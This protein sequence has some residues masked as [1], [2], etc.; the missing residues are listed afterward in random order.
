MGIIWSYL[1]KSCSSFLPQE[2]LWHSHQCWHELLLSL[3]REQAEQIVT[4]AEE[5]SWLVRV[6]A[7]QMAPVAVRS[8]TKKK[9]NTMRG[10]VGIWHLFCCYSTRKVCV[11]LQQAGTMS[12]EARELKPD[13]SLDYR[14]PQG[15]ITS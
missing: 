12:S 1:E 7:G 14:G 8:D 3:V 6:R 4:A 15:V 13:S 10:D 11:P 9:K 2:S 5:G